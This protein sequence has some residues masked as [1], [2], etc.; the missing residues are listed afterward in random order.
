MAHY[1]A[2]RADT[3]VG[4]E[5]E[6]FEAVPAASVD[7]RQAWDAAAS[8]VSAKVKAPAGWSAL[9]ASLEG[10]TALP[11]AAGN[12]PQAV[13]DVM[14]L[15]RGNGVASPGKREA[16]A[17]ED[18]ALMAWAG[19][20]A[21]T[22]DP[23]AW[24]LAAG[25]L[26]RARQFD[27]AEQLLAHKQ[28]EMPAEWADALANELAALAWHRGQRDEAAKIWENLPDSAASLFNRGLAE[29]TAGRARQ[30][31]PLLR[32][33]VAKLAETSPWHHLAQLYIALAESR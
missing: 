17:P 21:Q 6:P 7:A 12:Y 29:L 14:A 2:G 20:L 23:A 18:R 1:M 8:P 30:A 32:A 9:V 10:Q 25:V 15:L 19:R 22:N 26:R 3:P 33:A 16:S 31:E 24:L 28:P 4:G 27:A 11:M 13:R 5:V